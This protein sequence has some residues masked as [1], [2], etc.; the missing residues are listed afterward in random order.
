MRHVSIAVVSIAVVLVAM[1]LGCARPLTCPAAGGPPWVELQSPHFLLRTDLDEVEAKEMIVHFER[2]YRAFERVA[3]PH[4]PKPNGL[5]HVV[6]FDDEDAFARIAPRGAGGYLSRRGNDLEHVPTLMFPGG[7]SDAGREI[8]QH[9]LS[10]RFFAY[11]FPSAPVWLNEGM[12]EF[13]STLRI[14]ES[15]VVL[16][17]QLPDRLITTGSQWLSLRIDGRSVVGVPKAALPSVPTLLSLDAAAFYAWD[18]ED[19]TSR[20]ARMRRSANY[21]AAWA[22]VHA[23]QIEDDG[24]HPGFLRYLRALSDA[25]DARDRTLVDAFGDMPVSALERAL[26]RFVEANEIEVQTVRRAYVDRAPAVL[27]RMRSMRDEDVH[28]LWA[29][30]RRWSD[31]SAARAAAA[32]LN[33]AVRVGH[34]R[35]EPYLARGTFRWD[36]GDLAGARS[37]LERAASLAPDEPRYLYPLASFYTRAEASL[38]LEQRVW[39]DIEPLVARL[40][41]RATSQMQLDYLARYH[42]LRRRFGRALAY[43]KRAVDGNASCSPCYETLADIL[44]QQA[45]TADAVRAQR[46]AI[47]ILGDDQVSDTSLRRLWYYKQALEQAERTSGEE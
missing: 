45:K 14:E 12:A 3:F 42:A 26:T 15:S 20:E 10:H 43:V 32:D 35:P 30:L 19:P 36:R 2:I 39:D 7:L 46:I 22:L 31:P 23:L 8:F 27:P 25:R 1:A 4:E 6:V 21:T 16:G 24:L 11:Y 41:P 9:E 34:E 44:F 37:D 28:A 18:V 47:N 17:K 13:Y 40:E 5:T 38:P 33:E 29:R